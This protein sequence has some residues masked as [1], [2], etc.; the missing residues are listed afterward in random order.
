MRFKFWP[1]TL[2]VQLILV[3]AIAV[4]VSNM[5]VALWFEYSNEQQIQTNLTDR[6][7]DRATAVATT[8]STVAGATAGA[9]TVGATVGATAGA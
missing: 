3:T 6:V 8:P 9:T 5:A 4:A 1:R 7:L 2:A